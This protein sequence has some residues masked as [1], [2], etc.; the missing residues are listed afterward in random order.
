MK[1]NNNPARFATFLVRFAI[2][3]SI[4]AALLAAACC[5]FPL[6]DSLAAFT[7]TGFLIAYSGVQIVLPSGDTEEIF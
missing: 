3:L 1:T 2:G 5:L 6:M 4:I 7:L